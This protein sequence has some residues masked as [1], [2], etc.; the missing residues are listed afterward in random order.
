MCRPGTKWPVST[1]FPGR[2]L[3]QRM[4]R[5]PPIER[6]SATFEDRGRK[7]LMP[8]VGG[9]LQPSTFGDQ[10]NNFLAIVGIQAHHWSECAMVTAVLRKLAVR[11]PQPGRSNASL[12][13]KERHRCHRIQSRSQRRFWRCSSALFQTALVF[14]AGRELDAAVAG[15]KPL[16]HDRP[17]AE[18]KHDPGPIR[19]LGCARTSMRF[20]TAAIS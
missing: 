5:A 2:S 16:H 9:R 1:S 18:H 6:L 19:R 7:Q 8:K 10:S 14:L 13:S 12:A 15:G 4:T 11:A 3:G 17:G 20:S